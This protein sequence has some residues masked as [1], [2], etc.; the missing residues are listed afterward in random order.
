MAVQLGLAVVLLFC[1]GLLLRSFAG[2]LGVERGY[3]VDRVLT[4]ST[5]VPSGPYPDFES[6]RALYEGVLERIEDLPGVEVA[7]MAHVL[8]Y[9]GRWRFGVSVDGLEPADDE[10]PASDVLYVTPS[11][12]DALS[13]PLLEG[14]TFRNDETGVTVVNRTL[15]RRFLADRPAL[16]TMVTLGNNEPARVIG[17]VDDTRYVDL[18]EE[19]TPQAYL[20]YADGFTGDMM[21]VVRTARNPSALAGPVRELFAAR[22]PGI[23]VSELLTLRERLTGS[24]S[25]PRFRT[26]LLG[27]FAVAALGLAVVGVYGVMAYTVTRRTREMGIRMA[28]GADRRRILAAVL[29]Q[30]ALLALLG[31]ALGAVGSWAA[32]GVLESYLF[33]VEARDPVTFAGVAL[34]LSAAALVACW[35]PAR[36]AGRIDP[37]VALRAD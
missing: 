9:G 35:V 4:F 26:V 3:E 33:G 2:L 29:R 34:V 12:F 7:S 13:I 25:G 11:F 23:A 24:V 1:G 16:G 15:T 8:P 6:R 5:S 18:D 17:V 27:A 32:A 21:G 28:L 20:P 10:S 22:D 37:M 31:L 36:R 14:R 19:A 30:A